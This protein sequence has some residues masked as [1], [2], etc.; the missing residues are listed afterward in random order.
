MKQKESSMY[1]LGE[2]LSSQ[3]MYLSQQTTVSKSKPAFSL[4]GQLFLSQPS[5]KSSIHVV[6]VLAHRLVALQYPGHCLVWGVGSGR[7]HVKACKRKKK[8]RVSGE[9]QTDVWKKLRTEERYYSMK[10]KARSVRV[11]NSSPLHLSWKP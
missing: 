3:L 5:H 9:T 7:Q 2:Q 1:I 10:G 6:D 4:R 11:L 8:K